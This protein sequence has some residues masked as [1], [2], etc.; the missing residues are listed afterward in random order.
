MTATAVLE[1][2]HAAAPAG[3][4]GAGVAAPARTAAADL[5]STIWR[6]H[7][8]ALLRFAL[9]LSLGDRQRAEDI[10]QETLLRAW[11]HPEV[12]EGREEMIRPWLFTVTR[13]VS[14]DMW[15]AR[16]RNEEIIE[17]EPAD[18][19][20]PAERIEQ[21]VTALDVR[22]ALARLAP[23]HQQ[24]IVEMY[25]YGQHVDEIAR[26]LGVPAG[27]VK[28]RAHYALRQLRRVLSAPYADA[29]GFLAP[30]DP[31]ACQQL[32]ALYLNTTP[33][34]RPH[35]RYDAVGRNGLD[36]GLV[37][38]HISRR[39]RCSPGSATGA[40]VISRRV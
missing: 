15:R 10:V 28:S 25:Y 18:R 40:A 30:Q 36:P 6:L 3:G 13:N 32:P 27:T 5:M 38:R 26:S 17:D 24:V 33:G 14:V 9:K 22:A 4:P 16:S 21:A 35:H 19:P 39:R 20:D 37:A 34:N 7:G 8:T 12:A 31:G 1:P 29:A 11:R 2:D 23:K